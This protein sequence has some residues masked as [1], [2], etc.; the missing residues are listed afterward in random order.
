MFGGEEGPRL[1]GV[2]ITAERLP[3]SAAASLV[4]LPRYI[5]WLLPGNMTLVKDP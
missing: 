5:W 3:G 1:G 4:L 2:L